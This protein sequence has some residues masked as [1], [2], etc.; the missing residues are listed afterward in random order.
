MA[1][2]ELRVHS[3]LQAASKRFDEER[4]VTARLSELN[5]I[6]EK[7]YEYEWMCA[8]KLRA[9]SH[10]AHFGCTYSTCICPSVRRCDTLSSDIA[11]LKHSH[12]QHQQP[13]SPRHS[14]SAPPSELLRTRLERQ[15][16]DL[17]GALE[18]Q[19]RDNAQLQQENSRFR[20]ELTNLDPRFFEEIEGPPL[21]VVGR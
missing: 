12:E 20:Q 1:G 15:I 21:F 19:K 16:K 17:E 8:R 6:L 9:V 5:C 7:R 3:Q 11:Q 13:H 4:I 18:A 10:P 2:L 14:P